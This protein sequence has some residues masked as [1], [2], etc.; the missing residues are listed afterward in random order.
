MMILI[1]RFSREVQNVS[2]VLDYEQ[3]RSIGQYYCRIIL[4]I[5]HGFLRLE[6]I[7]YHRPLNLQIIRRV[8][9][10]YFLIHQAFNV[11][12]RL[13]RGPFD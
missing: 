6:I 9:D 7:R 11:T 5:F 4:I 13:P 10:V 3:L 2:G 12:H 1:N 8:I